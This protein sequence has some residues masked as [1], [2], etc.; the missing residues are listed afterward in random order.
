MRRIVRDTPVS[1]RVAAAVLLPLVILVGLAAYFVIFKITEGRLGDQLRATMETVPAISGVIH[2]LQRERG[3]SSGYI[4]SNGAA[5][6]KRLADQR[7]RTDAAVRKLRTVMAYG[8]HKE[9]VSRLGSEYERVIT[10]LKRLEDVRK[11]VSDFQFNVEDIVAYYSGI[12]SDLLDIASELSVISNNAEI[13]QAASAYSALMRAKEATGLQRAMGSVGFGAGRF[14]QDVYDRF[15]AMIG[16]E[17]AYIDIFKSFTD[18]DTREYFDAILSDKAV[19][20]VTRMQRVAHDSIQNGNTQ[21]VK[22]EQWFSAATSKIDLLRTVEHR[23]AEALLRV[24]QQIR[25]R[26]R[27][28]YRTL[29]I[30]VPILASLIVALALVMARSVTAPIAS[31]MTV[32]RRLMDGESATEI[33]ESDRKDEIGSI[34]RA[35]KAFRDLTERQKTELAA[36]E[37]Q[38]RQILASTSEG[39][40]KVRAD[41]SIALANPAGAIMLGYL[42][43]DMAGKSIEIFLHS[44]HGD[45]EQHPLQESPIFRTANDGQLRKISRET[46]WRR[47]CSSFPVEYCVTPLRQ[48]GQLIGAVVSFHDIAERE[49]N[50]RAL[51]EAK[52]LAEAA[53]RAKADFL[54]NM[55]HE[56]R[57]PMN[58]II[59]MT[60]LALK[61]DPNPRQYGY[62]SKIQQAGR[63]LLEIINN[64]LDFSK[65]ES[66]KMALDVTNV[67]LSKVLESVCSMVSEKASAKNLELIFDIDDDVPNEMV[68]DPLRLGQIL[69]NYVNNAVKF[70]ERGE[71]SVAVRCLDDDETTVTLRFD[72]RDSGIGLSEEQK[73]RLF[74]CFEQ[75]DTSISRE[76]GGTGLGLVIAKR[77]AEMMGGSV[78]VDS[79]LGQGSTFWFVARLGKRNDGGARLSKPELSDRHVLVVDDSSSAREALVHMLTA[80][81]LRVQSVASGAAAIDA[82]RASF[83]DPFDIVFVDWRMP[84]MDG[85]Q[86]CASIK[87]LSSTSPR[88][89]LVTAFDGDEAFNGAESVGCDA[90]LIKPV[91]PSTMLDAIMRV[92]WLETGEIDDS[93]DDVIAEVVP[94]ATALI[95]A[96]ILVV[97]DNEFNQQVATEILEGFGANVEIASNGAV[98]VTKVTFGTFDAVLMDMQMPVMDGITATQEIRKLG[99]TNLPIVAMTANAMQQDRERCLAA[100]MD[101]HLAKP[102]NPQELAETL[103]KWI[104]R[105]ETESELSQTEQMNGSALQMFNRPGIPIID[106]DVFDFEVLGSIYQWDVDKLR[107]TLSGFLE[108]A[109]KHMSTLEALEDRS[110]LRQVAHSLKG[111]ANTAGAKKLARLAADLE[112]AAADEDMDSLRAMIGMMAEAYSDVYGA[113]N[114][115][116]LERMAHASA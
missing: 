45:A 36:A 67:T 12:V 98:A 89:V 62:L 95:G 69:I 70:T 8:L 57:T 86:V 116:V 32:L 11:N 91:T 82:V 112:V 30:A 35:L 2:E 61:T 109:S 94:S 15:L 78:G 7:I 37:D 64:I 20:D 59:G 60:D 18:A 65:Y 83:A 73:S 14:E 34:A 71:V 99:F 52:E 17:N 114:Q 13:F 85:L 40:I 42:P 113:L 25:D 16:R 93:D 66:G 54:A 50:E 104:G 75:G 110:R 115:F 105:R 68:G 74:Q 106:A 5:F 87:Q 47:D 27:T 19:A 92:L 76:Y 24:A 44:P 48:D 90:V 6:T 84:V 53:S 102:V 33:A 80:M 9:D 101:D 4:G 103:A 38:F 43:E 49:R 51:Q 39:I 63:H 31:L 107:S 26:T 1:V 29:L 81:S 72:V 22:A 28:H 108:H 46:L 56:I 88:L 23:Q 79:A 55:S 100:G 41:G 10:G 21:G 97:E 96:S 77:L 3:M 58:A 111:T